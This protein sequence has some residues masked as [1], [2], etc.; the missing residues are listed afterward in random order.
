M[1]GTL[2][3]GPVLIY[4]DEHYYMGGVL[5][6]K[7]CQLGVP[8]TLLTP[9][10]DVSAFTHNTLEQHR[11]QKNLLDMGVDI[12]PAHTL[13]GVEADNVRIACIYTGR[14]KTLAAKSVVLVTAMLPHDALL[15]ELE[16]KRGA[17]ADAGIQ[18][19]QAIGDARVPG[20]IA[21][22]VWGGHQYAQ[23]LGAESAG[24][25]PFKREVV[26]ILRAG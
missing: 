7:L 24:D 9:A 3:S 25:V 16:S 10:T 12:I 20:T 22:A 26:E 15:H 23:E 4:D 1:R 5:A 19:V 11:I 2:P 14:E 17:W 6:E 18:S 8:V 13:A 21:A